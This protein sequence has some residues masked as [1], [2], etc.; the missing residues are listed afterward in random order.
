MRALP[1][2][3]LRQNVVAIV[4]GVI[5]PSGLRALSRPKCPL[6]TALFLVLSKVV[7]YL[8]EGVIIGF[9]SFALGFKSKK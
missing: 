4:L 2:A 1:L 8:P 6:L 7:T 5:G 9:R 3:V